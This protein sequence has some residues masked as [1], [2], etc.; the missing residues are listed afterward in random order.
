MRM[1][2]GAATPGFVDGMTSRLRPDPGEPPSAPMPLLGC[3][4]APGAKAHST[5]MTAVAMRAMA[6]PYQRLWVSSALPTT[7]PSLEIPHGDQA[8][9]Q[10]A[11]RQADGKHGIRFGDALRDAAEGS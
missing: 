2:S 6:T 9:R 8:R 5:I 3:A 10:A 1:S 7:I 4:A 11:R